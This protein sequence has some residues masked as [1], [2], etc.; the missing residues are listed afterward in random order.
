MIFFLEIG[1]VQFMAAA[2]TQYLYFIKPFF[3]AYLS[4]RLWLFIY[5]FAIRLNDE[6]KDFF[7]V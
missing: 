6:K 1:R 3:Q 2:H 5:I 7:A 4:I